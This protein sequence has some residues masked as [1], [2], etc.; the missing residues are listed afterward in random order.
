MNKTLIT[1]LAA[2]ALAAGCATTPNRIKSDEA[3]ERYLAYAGEPV[4][5]FT[6]FRLQSWQPLGR[7]K[8]ML[9][10]GVND[11]YLVT[12]WETCRDLQFA[13]S[14]RVRN[15]GSSVST[16]DSIQVGRDRCRIEEIRPVDIRRMKAEQHAARDGD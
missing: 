5:E 8:L 14:I 16:F 9:W 10:T 2:A 6:A 3:L 15:T 1:L 4:R 7:D 13:N 12:V 11:A